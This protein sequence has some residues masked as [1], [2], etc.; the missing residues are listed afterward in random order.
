VA[1]LIEEGADINRKDKAGDTP[2]HDAINHGEPILALK[3]I[4]SMFVIV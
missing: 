2:F 4:H 1:K 3:K